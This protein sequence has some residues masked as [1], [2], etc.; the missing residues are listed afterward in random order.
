MNVLSLFDGISCGQEALKRAGI[1]VE[2]YYASEVD[3]WAIQ[4]TQKNY[5][6]TI[7]LGDIQNWRDWD[8]PKI[9]LIIGGSPCQGFSF[10]GK[11]LNFE[12]PRSKLF[13]DYVDI[14]NHYQSKYFLLENVKMNQKSQNVISEYLK[15]EPMFINSSLVSAQSRKRLYWFNWDVDEPKDRNIKLK[16]ILESGFIDRDKSY[17]IDASYY[18]GTGL[19]YYFNKSARQGVFEWKPARI[20]GRRLNEQ[21]IRKDYDKSI[22][23]VQCLEVK[24]TDKSNCLTTVHKDYVISKLKNGRYK[25]AYNELKESTDWRKLTPIE[26]ERLQTLPDNYTE[27][28]SNSQRYKSIGNGWTVDIIVHLLNGIKEELN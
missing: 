27:G 24:K 16:D 2:N 18:K 22:D 21:G 19:E 4:I 26:C 7:Q 23:I 1:K 12:D 20:V 14:L 3:K 10:A 15:V 17:C 9:D 28:I 8:L 11:G 6:N 13:F 25:D 5:P